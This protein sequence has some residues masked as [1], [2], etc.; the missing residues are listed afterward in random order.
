MT[1]IKFLHLSSVNQLKLRSNKY[2][3]SLFKKG[4]R[5]EIFNFIFK[6]RNI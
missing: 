2:S 3:K 1:I 5:Q 4:G 6:V